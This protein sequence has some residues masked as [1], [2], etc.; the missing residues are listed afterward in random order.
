M[1]GGT[2]LFGGRGKIVGTAGGVLLLALVEN[3]CTLMHVPS[4]YQ[5]LARGAVIVAAVAVF[6][7]KG[8]ID[9]GRRTRRRVR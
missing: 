6:L 9:L 8:L 4:F 2:S 3:A 7:R 5:D 1:P